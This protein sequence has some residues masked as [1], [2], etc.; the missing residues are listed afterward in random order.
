MNKDRL[1]RLVALLRQNAA[2]PKGVKFDMG[3]WGKTNAWGHERA[4]ASCGT[5]AC[6]FGLAAISGEFKADG[7]SY[8]KHGFWGGRIAVVYDWAE[9][10]EAAAKFFDISCD[11]AHYL[12]DART[13]VNTTGADAEIEVANKIE[14]YVNNGGLH[15]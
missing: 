14:R 10:F 3:T 9:G 8:Q 12:F 2:N 11:D 6:A 15:A 7:L 1:L 13:Y 4:P 5:A